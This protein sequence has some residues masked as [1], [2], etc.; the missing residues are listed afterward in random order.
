MSPNF[1]NTRAQ[2]VLH[3]FDN[4]S[5][6]KTFK[7]FSNYINV[8]LF[9]AI[10]NFPCLCYN[11]N[12]F[13]FS[14]KQNQI[15]VESRSY[16]YSIRILVI[17][18]IIFYYF[19][20]R[21]HDFSSLIHWIFTKLDGSMQLVLVMCIF[22]R[23]FISFIILGAG[24]LFSFSWHFIDQRTYWPDFDALRDLGSSSN[25]DSVEWSPFF[26]IS[27]G[28]RDIKGQTSQNDP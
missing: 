19:F 9:S 6:Y 26:S 22:S 16:S 24:S 8:L 15:G 28:F 12:L 23:I 13:H 3:H 1:I 4:I 20:S 21:E 7:T 5:V 11:I 27:Y 25:A 18:I 14:T 10:F 17:I 2:I